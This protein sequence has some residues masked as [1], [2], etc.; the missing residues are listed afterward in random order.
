MSYIARIEIDMKHMHE[1]FILES[2]IRRQG[3]SAHDISRA[4]RSNRRMVYNWFSQRDLDPEVIKK[5]GNAINYDF[6][7]DFP[8][9]ILKSKEDKKKAKVKVEYS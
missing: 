5:I 9:N 3:F 2:A 4:L 8:E 6:S 7:E 1:G